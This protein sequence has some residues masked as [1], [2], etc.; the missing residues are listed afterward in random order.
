VALIGGYIV[1]IFVDRSWL[2]K[3]VMLSHFRQNMSRRS[4]GPRLLGYCLSNSSAV[5]HRYGYGG[6]VTKGQGLEG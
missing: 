2:L 3:K 5:K 6:L 4:S 1:G